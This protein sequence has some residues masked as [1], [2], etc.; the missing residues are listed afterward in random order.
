MEWIPHSLTRVS[1]SCLWHIKVP[2]LGARG[3]VSLHPREAPP[4]HRS[5]LRR[6]SP[7]HT[8]QS[9]RKGGSNSIVLQLQ[10]AHCGFFLC[11]PIASAALKEQGEGT[12]GN[13]WHTAGRS[14]Q[15]PWKPREVPQSL[16]S[17]LQ[18]LAPSSNLGDKGSRAQ[19]SPAS[20]PKT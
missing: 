13:R 1:R 14:Q 11:L 20:Q 16:L 17:P 19:L 7:C 9:R 10:E 18:P 4:S 5:P 8:R 3:E 2:V 15:K 12:E 6:S